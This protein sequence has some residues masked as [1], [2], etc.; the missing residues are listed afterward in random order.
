MAPPSIE[1]TDPKKVSKQDPPPTN[2]LVREADFM[3]MHEI[4]IVDL[5]GEILIIC[6]TCHEELGA[7]VD[8]IS[9][10]EILQCIDLHRNGPPGID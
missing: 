5:L 2:P 9:L 1:N 10:R 6:D 8:E 4:T 7:R 3:S